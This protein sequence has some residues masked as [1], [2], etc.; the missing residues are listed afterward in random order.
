MVKIIEGDIFETDL[1]DV[2]VHQA[3]L[4]H[5]FGA[6]IA[7]EIAKRFPEAF[8]ADKL[9]QYGD[10]S[11]LGTYSYAVVVSPHPH[12]LRF[13]INLYSQRDLGGARGHCNTSYDAMVKGLLTLRAALEKHKWNLGIPYLM[14]CGLAGGNWRIVESIIRSIFE[15][16]CVAAYIFDIT[17][18][19]DNAL[20][21]KV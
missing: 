21:K 4:Y 12:P 14:G 19:H 6:G 17:H 18:L 7:A 11:K 16:S 20:S 5:T 13:I 15:D 3:N 2:I 10:V 8:E 1:C 9:T